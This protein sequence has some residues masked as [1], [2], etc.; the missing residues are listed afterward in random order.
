M[1]R[2]FDV[3]SVFQI[4]R[5]FLNNDFMELD[6]MQVNIQRVEHDLRQIEQIYSK[7]HNNKDNLGK[8]K[9]DIKMEK[10]SKYNINLTIDCATI[11]SSQ[12]DMQSK[13]TRCA[14]IALEFLSWNRTGFAERLLNDNDVCEVKVSFRSRVIKCLHEPWRKLQF[15]ALFC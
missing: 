4:S 9:L 15:I 7:L 1:G 5:A 2:R 10:G 3:N 14:L 6:K 12:S 11:C 13:Q 8:T